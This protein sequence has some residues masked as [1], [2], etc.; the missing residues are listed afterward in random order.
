M[1]AKPDKETAPHWEGPRNQRPVETA[2]EKHS[3][4]TI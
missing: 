3:D 1:S 2:L 4:H